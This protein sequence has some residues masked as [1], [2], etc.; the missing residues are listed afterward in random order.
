VDLPGSGQAAHR[1]PHPRARR[2]RGK[3]NFDFFARGSVNR[4]QVHRDQQGQ[5]GD[6]SGARG[7]REG[8]TVAYA[9][10]LPSGGIARS[11]KHRADAQPLPQLA[12]AAQNRGFGEL[13]AQLFPG[14]DR[15]QRPILFQGLP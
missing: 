13:A 10:K 6:L 2:D 5:G 4:L 15:C 14:L 7:G 11:G 1:F 9:Q 12:Q 3:K 8:I